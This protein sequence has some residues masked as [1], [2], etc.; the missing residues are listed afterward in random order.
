MWHIHLRKYC[1]ITRRFTFSVRTK[2]LSINDWRTRRTVCG[3]DLYIHDY[4]CEKMIRSFFY[5]TA[6]LFIC[7]LSH[8]SGEWMMPLIEKISHFIFFSNV[9]W[10]TGRIDE[11]V[12]TD[13]KTGK[14]AFKW[15]KEMTWKLFGKLRFHCKRNVAALAERL[16]FV[17]DVDLETERMF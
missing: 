12:L 17:F 8:S 16:E 14:E 4:L 5:P 3:A 9:I 13:E 11:R 10:E 6:A 15:R 1:H 7:F 2:Q